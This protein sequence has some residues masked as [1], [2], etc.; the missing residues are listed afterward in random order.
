MAQAN[1][2]EQGF[3]RFQETV[4]DVDKQVQRVRRELVKRRR[5]VEKE[6]RRRRT[7]IEKRATRRIRQLRSELRRNSTFRRA[8]TLQAE[9]R[10]RIEQQIDQVLSRVPVASK[11][12]VEGLEK[13]IARLTRR[14]RDLEKT[15]G[16]AEG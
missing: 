7:D 6:L 16:V 5:T 1:V 8:E 12:D 13:R 2:F 14:V 15:N 4:K 9:T 11:S 3:D 10:E